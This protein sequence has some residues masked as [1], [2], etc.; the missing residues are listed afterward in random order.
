MALLF[1]LLLVLEGTAESSAAVL[2]M[3]DVVVKVLLGDCPFSETRS[4]RDKHHIALQRSYQSDKLCLNTLV[5]EYQFSWPLQ[6]WS[7]S[8]AWNG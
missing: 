7:E 2:L 4:T 1:Y 5:L 8:T 6:P 3:T